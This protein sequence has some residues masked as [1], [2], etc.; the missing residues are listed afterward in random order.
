MTY[1]IKNNPLA[2]ND[3]QIERIYITRGDN[4]YN[5]DNVKSDKLM[6]IVIAGSIHWIDDEFA[7]A[8]QLSGLLE[9]LNVILSSNGRWGV[10]DDNCSATLDQRVTKISRSHD[11]IFSAK[12]SYIKRTKRTDAGKLY[13]TWAELEE[14]YFNNHLLA[15]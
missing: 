6:G 12:S 14:T 10:M 11:D 1:S 2:D 15:G 9:R 13:W 7:C 5:S 8:T 4:T 3:I